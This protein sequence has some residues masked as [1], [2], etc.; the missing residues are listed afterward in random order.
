MAHSGDLGD[1]VDDLAFAG[2][3]DFD[4]LGKGFGMGGEVAILF[5]A[6]AGV[7]LIGD[8]TSFDADALAVAL[9]NDVLIFH[10]DE[11]LLHGRTSCIDDQDFHSLTTIPCFFESRCRKNDN[12]TKP[13]GSDFRRIFPVRLDFNASTLYISIIGMKFQVFFSAVR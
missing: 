3:Q 10:V 1:G 12:K 7:G 13:E 9:G 4:D 6:D 2:G 5:F 11:L 8:E